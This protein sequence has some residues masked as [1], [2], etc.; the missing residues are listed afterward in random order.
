MP[1]LDA[2]PG[3]RTL[4]QTL[5][6]TSRPRAGRR[7]QPT[8][9]LALLEPAL[10]ACWSLPGTHRGLT[11]VQEMTGPYGI[12]DLTAVVG[13][14]EPLA[15]RLALDVPPLLNQVDAGIVSAAH[16][17]QARPLRFFAEHLNWPLDTVERRVPELLRFGALIESR[18]ARF[19]RPATLTTIGRIYAVETKVREWNQALRQGRTYSIWADSYL[20]VMGPLSPRTQI[21][22]HAEVV[23]DRAGLLIDGKWVSRPLLHPLPAARRLWASEHVAAALTTAD[24]QPSAIP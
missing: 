9:E 11:V 16:H 18:P 3:Q 4:A 10:E 21:A 2:S 13:P 19:V 12:P 1:V 7:F 17:Q 23:N 6:D 14:P 5:R 20:L 8:H 15:D 22:L 24:Y